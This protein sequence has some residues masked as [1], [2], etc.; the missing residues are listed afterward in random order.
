MVTTLQ[1]QLDQIQQQPYPP[2]HPAESES[3]DVSDSNS[4]ASSGSFDDDEKDQDT[5]SDFS[6]LTAI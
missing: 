3:P 5:V 6:F 4:T 1:H 2:I